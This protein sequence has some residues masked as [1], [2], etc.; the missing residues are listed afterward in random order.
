MI[1]EKHDH[2]LIQAKIP[3]LWKPSAYVG[4]IGDMRKAWVRNYLRNWE[5]GGQGT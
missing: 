1:A 4:T 3:R 5:S 2:L